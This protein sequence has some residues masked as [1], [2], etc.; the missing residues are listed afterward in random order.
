MPSDKAIDAPSAKAKTGNRSGRLGGASADFV[1]SLG[2]K[3]ADARDVLRAVEDDPAGSRSRD[4]LRR[5]LHALGA[6]ARLLRFDA[7]ARSLQEAET[8]LE[9]AAKLGHVRKEDTTF[10]AQL[11]D[12]LP[13]LAWGEMPAH[14]PKSAV[15]LG[16][17]PATTAPPAQQPLPFAALV[18]GSEELAEALSDDVS[19]GVR[20]FEVERS[21]DAQAAVDLARVF[22]PDLV[23][24]D[25]EIDSAP[26][27]VEALLDDPLT[28]PVPIIV[29][30]TFAVPEQASRFVALGVAKVLPK[31][32]SPETLR[33]T[34]EEIIDQREGRTMRLTLGEPTLEQLGNRLAEEVKRALVDSVDA[35][36]RSIRVPLGEGSEVLGAIWGA[37]AR[38]QE[39]ITAKTEGTIRF[40]GGAPEGAIALAPWLHHEMPGAERMSGRG[41]GAAADV[42]LE[43]R[44][45][46]VADD[47]PGVTWFIADL[48]RT[49]GC[50]V[51]EAL[52]GQSAL[53]LAFKVSPEIIV[54]DILMPG[55][56]GFALCRA[57]KRDV[58][59]RDTPVILLS[60]KEDLLQ[61]V[62]EL[63][64]SAAGYLKKES[65][66]R[67]ILARVREVLRPRARIESRLRGSD[68]VRGRLDGLTVRLLLE[69]V[70]QLRSS[71]RIC[72]RDA[73]FLY[74]VDIR[75][76]APKRATRTATDGTF[77]H[78][79]RVLARMLGVGAGRFIVTSKGETIEQELSG[80][81]DQQL[82]RPIS[83]ARG[84]LFATTGARTMNVEHI[85]I[86]DVGLEDY[87]RVT[88]DPA[89]DIITRIARGASPRKMLLSGQVAP[90]LLEDVL[91]DLAARGA[92]TG[93]R[94]AGGNDL[95][96][97]AV[98]AAYAVLEGKAPRRSMSLPP[99]SSRS[100]GS[101]RTERASGRP[102]SDVIADEIAALARAPSE[103]GARSTNPYETFTVSEP[104]PPAQAQTRV[105]P[106]PSSLEDAV[107]RTISGGPEKNAERRVASSPPPIIEPSELRPR[108]SNPPPPPVAMNE[109]ADRR[110][111]PSLPP[112]AIVPGSVLDEM[113][114]LAPLDIE[115][116]EPFAHPNTMPLG[117]T[118]R[119]ATPDPSRSTTEPTAP[120]GLAGRVGRVESPR[121]PSV[122]TA[123]VVAQSGKTK[124][125]RAPVITDVEPPSGTPLSPV[126]VKTVL[127]SAPPKRSR[128]GLAFVGAVIVLALLIGIGLHWSS[129]TVPEPDLG[130]AVPPPDSRS[131]KAA[132]ATT[133][134]PS[135]PVTVPA[136]T[137]P[138]ADP[139]GAA[140]ADL[141]S[142]ASV[143]AGQGLLVITAG[144]DVPITIDSAQVGR[145]PRFTMPVAPGKHDVRVGLAGR[146][147]RRTVD[148]RAGRAT[149]VDAP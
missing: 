86:D 121:E 94:D 118:P 112:D 108:S 21:E 4:D 38:V 75:D 116:T 100:P 141:P 90:T 57:V 13:A 26:E 96:T 19:A 95:L 73:S 48:L 33:R 82:A 129:S 65:D 79:E 68:E 117:L 104:P 130:S 3:V 16:E 115:L 50:E 89:R 8:V 125:M 148:V 92:I 45:V 27:L 145:G 36:A 7:M 140:F 11:L 81:L 23:I 52:D 133:T 67:A 24:I 110:A 17:D 56:D 142:G 143:P 2:R 59:L 122:P 66:A 25:A 98:D 93:V 10:L 69:L 132:A 12:D 6:G 60:W 54:S 101:G 34:C 88:P 74:E 20:S 106:V 32:V 61:R 72:V 22:A 77:Q 134:Q 42:R 131:S 136:G 111:L 123:R 28:E 64:A 62:R 128:S 5:K 139:A 37:I 29:V 39:V 144:I 119:P 43:R 46:V 76:G 58:A 47:D 35:P 30:G 109:E 70:G 105:S 83:L 147:K 99:A 91:A 138:P 44:R 55:L 18:I 137:A 120:Q 40:G 85:A 51:H 9:R 63:G 124:P 80:T 103:T 126:A 146:E 1:A 53:D 41:R 135:L 87:V 84:A 15:V 78:G 97:P 31:P 107:M 113:H 114:A 149:L 71:A 102:A 49:A 14:E 127:P